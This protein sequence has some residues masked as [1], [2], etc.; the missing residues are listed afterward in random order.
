MKLNAGESAGKTVIPDGEDGIWDGH[1]IVMKTD[2]DLGSL[3]GRKIYETGTVIM[4]S[5]PDTPS[6]GAGMFLIY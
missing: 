3:K 4:P 5:D 1:G 6:T 2:N